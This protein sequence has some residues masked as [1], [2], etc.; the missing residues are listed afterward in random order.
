MTPVAGDLLIAPNISAFWDELDFCTPFV[1]QIT[2]RNCF[3]ATNAASRIGNWRLVGHGM[4][5]QSATGRSEQV[6]PQ[7]DC[8]CAECDRNFQMPTD[9]LRIR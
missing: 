8:H 7:S 2:V 4:A 1:E 3:A 5:L 6:K 9:L